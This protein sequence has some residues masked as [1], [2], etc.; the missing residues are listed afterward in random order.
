[1][2]QVARGALSHLTLKPRLLQLAADVAPCRP[3]AREEVLVS[4]AAELNPRDRP[5]LSGMNLLPAKN[6]H[7]VAVGVAQQKTVARVRARTVNGVRTGGE[8]RSDG[9]NP[10]QLTNFGGSHTGSPRWSPDGRLLAFDSRPAGLSNIYVIS[11]AGGSPRRLTDGKSEDLLPSWSHDGR[12]IY[13]GSRRSGD[14]QIWRITATGEQV[15]QVT[16]NGGYEAFEAADGKTLYYAKREPGIWRISLTS[17]AGGEETRILEQVTWG[18]W[19][20]FEQGICFLNQRALPQ[21]ALEF[22]NFATS[23]VRLFGRLERTRAF[24]GSPGLAV[25][26]D[27]RWVLYRQVDQIDNDIMLVENFR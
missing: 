4:V 17:G 13:F 16:K 6:H 7:R 20:L 10:V 27:G 19:A 8:R 22:F 11:A 18:Q 9:R 26:A 24:G 2:R 14:W 5:R 3:D 23:Q 1:M 15:E 21:P 12:W 25:S